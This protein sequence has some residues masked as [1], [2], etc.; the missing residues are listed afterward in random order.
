MENQKNKILNEIIEEEN[1]LQELV[2][3]LEQEIKNLKKETIKK[4][5]LLDELNQMVD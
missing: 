5:I 4:E 1:K 3:T 2:N